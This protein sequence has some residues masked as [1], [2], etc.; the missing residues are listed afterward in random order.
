MPYPSLLRKGV[1][2][3]NTDQISNVQR[4]LWLHEISD[5]D[6]KSK[7]KRADCNPHSCAS[8]TAIQRTKMLSTSCRLEGQFFYREV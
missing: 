4:E 5:I 7:R 2:V 6:F 1:T 3:N 8:S